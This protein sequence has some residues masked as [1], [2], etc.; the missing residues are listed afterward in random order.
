MDKIVKKFITMNLVKVPAPISEEFCLIITIF[1]NGFNNGIPYV[2]GNPIL[3]LPIPENI[4]TGTTNN[5]DRSDYQAFKFLNHLIDRYNTSARGDVIIGQIVTT[6]DVIFDNKEFW[7]ENLR[8]SLRG[9]E[10]RKTVSWKNFVCEVQ[11]ED[12]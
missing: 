2:T 11:I 3:T 6:L 8:Y 5:F 10:T 7:F 4:L 12:I 9:I 1:Q